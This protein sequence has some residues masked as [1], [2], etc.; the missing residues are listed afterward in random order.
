ML[1]VSAV[2]FVLLLER[3]AGSNATSRERLRSI[4]NRLVNVS[5]SY[6]N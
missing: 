2:V 3:G 1:D 5:K 6:K 4:Q